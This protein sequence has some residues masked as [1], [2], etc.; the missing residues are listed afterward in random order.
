[1]AFS[2]TERAWSRSF[3]LFAPAYDEKPTTATLIPLTSTTVTWSSA[4]VCSS[5][6]P[7][8]AFTVFW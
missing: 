3:S 5:P 4:P 1:V 7:S 6:A 8:S 2:T